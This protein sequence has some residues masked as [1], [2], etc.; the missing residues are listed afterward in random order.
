[1]QKAFAL[2]KGKAG[3]A[4]TSDRKSRVVFRV[5]DVIPAPAPTQ[6]QK[7]KL[8]TTLKGELTEDQLDAYVR[9]VTNKLGVTINEAELKRATGAGADTQ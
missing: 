9:G 6:E 2:A 8:A 1:M 4:N 3:S 7:D 5:A